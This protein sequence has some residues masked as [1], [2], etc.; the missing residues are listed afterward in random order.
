[1]SYVS[2][3]NLYHFRQRKIRRGRPSELNLN[4]AQKKKMMQYP[5]D[6]YSKVVNTFDPPPLLPQTESPQENEY[7]YVEDFFP[8]PPPAAILPAKEHS[9]SNTGP[10]PNHYEYT[11]SRALV[12][13][14]NVELPCEEC[15][16]SR[17]YFELDPDV[18]RG[19]TGVGKQQYY[20]GH[21]GQSQP[22]LPQFGN[23]NIN[24]PIDPRMGDHAIPHI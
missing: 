14:V 19:G 21:H 9:D 8:P 24:M 13:G 2:N 17:H 15:R 1:M 3:V 10:G 6:P 4:T 12:D 23:N 11:Q 18:T 5:E 22:L 20:C 16:E 7:A